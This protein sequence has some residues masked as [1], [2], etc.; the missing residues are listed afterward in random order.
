MNGFWKYKNLPPQKKKKI[1]F[2]YL[3]ICLNFLDEAS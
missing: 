1:K 3:I 2:Y